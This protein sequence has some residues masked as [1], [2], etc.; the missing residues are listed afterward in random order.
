MSEPTACPNCAAPL[1]GR[2]CHACGQ[3]RIEPEEQR[4]SWFLRQL[5][6]SL[7]MLDERFLGS[8]GRLLFRP[9]RL[10]RDWLEG[11]RK[12]NLAPLSL[13]LIANV[14]YFFYP[15]LSDLNLSLGEQLAQAHGPFAEA[16]VAARLEAR[17]I[18]FETYAPQYQA[19]ATNLAKVL[20][21]LHAPLFALVLMGLHFRRGR[22][23]VDHL[24][25]SLHF[26]AFLLFVVMVVPWL[27]WLV[28]SAT[29]LGSQALL[30]L[31]L[32]GIVLLYAWRQLQVA[33]AQSGWLALA[34]LPLLVAGVVLAH[35]VYRAAQF[36]LAFALS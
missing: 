8:L 25:V 2:Y 1:Q 29:G 15:P 6:E 18:D 4:L 24:A 33:Y 16:L 14:V 10:D 30:Q 19:E 12:R 32:A 34:K 36:F 35:L 20:V 21:I 5:V 13:F 28:V 31:T 3:K 9:G 7:T 23:F 17:G 26:W 27:L 11:R 22:F